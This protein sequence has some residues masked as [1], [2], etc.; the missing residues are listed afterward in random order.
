MWNHGLLDMALSDGQ[1]AQERWRG[2]QEMRRRREINRASRRRATRP[3]VCIGNVFDSA[4]LAPAQSL[5]AS[6]D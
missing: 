3:L 1:T 2:L 6:A 4:G 5:V